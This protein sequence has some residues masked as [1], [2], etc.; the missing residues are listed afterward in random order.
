MISTK[1]LYS[2][3][4]DDFDR[5]R[6]KM[7][8]CV[9]RFLHASYKKHILDIGCGNGKNMIFPDITF[10]GVDFCPEFV[11]ICRKRGMDVTESD[12][13]SLPFLAE[14]FDG[15]MAVASYHHLNNDK[16]R[17]KALREMY[18][19]LKKGGDVMIVV[20][21]KE[22]EDDSRFAF[23]SDVKTSAFGWDEYVEWKVKNGNEIYEIYERYYHIYGKGDLENE[24]TMLCPEFHV[25]SVEWEKGNWIALLR[26]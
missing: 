10:T 19:V 13:T 15:A 18:R 1:Q 23:H 2:Q 14:T 20:W 5:S 16:D 6:T 7:W 11:D 4:C 26:K 25:V 17:Q 24:I 9:K 12:M 21:A 22:Q 8:A 3:I